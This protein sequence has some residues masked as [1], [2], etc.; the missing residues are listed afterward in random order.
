MEK[1]VSVP[2]F[3]LMFERT[4]IED[5]A[6]LYDI[7]ELDHSS[8]E[9]GDHIER[10][11]WKPRDK[12][13]ESMFYRS[14]GMRGLAFGCDLPYHVIKVKELSNINLEIWIDTDC[15]IDLRNSFVHCG[16]IKISKNP[17]INAKKQPEDIGTS[18]L[19]MVGDM[20]KSIIHGSYKD[21]CWCCATD[22]YLSKETVVITGVCNYNAV[23][24][25]TNS[26]LW[27]Y[28]RKSR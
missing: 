15:L 13:F 2:L 3:D 16:K 25:Y 17:I 12:S 20:V 21:Y 19:L 18:L 24:L 11:Y 4:D 14:Y 10:L 5:D 1:V 6:L 27:P 8:E 28:K 7:V 23:T 22:V 9:K 26:D